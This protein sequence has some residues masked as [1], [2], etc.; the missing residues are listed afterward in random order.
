MIPTIRMMTDD[1]DDTDQT[2]ESDR[3]VLVAFYSATGGGS[4]WTGTNWGS[5]EPIDDWQG[6]TT[7]DDG[8]VTRLVLSS[9][10]LS[11]TIPSSLGNLSKLEELVLA[12][13]DLSGTIPSSLGNLT[14]LEELGLQSNS[15]LSGTIPSSLG[16]LS[17]LEE[18]DLGFNDLSGSIP[19]SLGN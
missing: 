17:K 14:N 5:D 1:T 8:R 18:L 6:V 19:S 7:N 11:G 10:G 2:Y 3:A 12:Y 16:S 13:T 4:D 15:H 9:R